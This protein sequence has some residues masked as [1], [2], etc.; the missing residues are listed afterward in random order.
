MTHLQ[1]CCSRCFN[2]IS[3]LAKPCPHCGYEHALTE[4]GK[5]RIKKLYKKKKEK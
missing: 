3:T 2:H 1:L 5:R 4:E